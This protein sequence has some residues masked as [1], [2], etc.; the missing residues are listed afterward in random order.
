MALKPKS[1]GSVVKVMML[2]SIAGVGFS[3]KIGEVVEVEADFASQ[4]IKAG[5]AKEVK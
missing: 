1:V 3:H 2:T 5:Y 4:L